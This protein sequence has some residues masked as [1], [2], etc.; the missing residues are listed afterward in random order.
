MKK[1]ML[2]GLLCIGF[3]ACVACDKTKEIR[4]EAEVMA[5]S[6]TLPQLLSSTGALFGN[7]SVKIGEPSLV[8]TLKEVGGHIRT[9]NVY[10]NRGITKAAVYS[11]ICVGSKVSFT[12]TVSVIDSS[13]PKE[14]IE[15][16]NRDLA[17]NPYYYM[18]SEPADDLLI[19]EPCIK[20][21]T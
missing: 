2:C 1:K 8:L 13:T 21:N 19:P 15:K 12:A 5:I 17:S 11:R 10:D 16:I 9:L 7:D 6:G 3:L 20:Q 4:I 14:K 18:G